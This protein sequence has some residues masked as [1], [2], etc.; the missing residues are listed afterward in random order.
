[1]GTLISVLQHENCHAGL[2]VVCCSV[3]NWRYVERYHLETECLGW[4]VVSVVSV[5]CK[6][7]PAFAF[8]VTKNR[9]ARVERLGSVWSA[10]NEAT[11]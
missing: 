5:T 9:T 1:M 6:D 10:S 2:F 3:I 11:E 8:G 4:S 7:M